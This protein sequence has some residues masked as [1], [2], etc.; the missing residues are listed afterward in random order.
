MTEV[1]PRS[2]SNEAF[3][4]GRSALLPSSTMTGERWAPAAVAATTASVALLL[5]TTQALVA[6][7]NASRFR[8]WE[9][10][11]APPPLTLCTVGA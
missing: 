11:A 4:D 5:V 8:A 9:V 2:R 1:T 6:S 3:A 10:P 7:V